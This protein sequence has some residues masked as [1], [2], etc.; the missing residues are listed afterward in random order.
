MKIYHL[1]H[2]S[3]LKKYVS[4]AYKKRFL[5]CTPRKQETL[6]N[7]LTKV[8]K[9]SSDICITVLQDIWKYKKLGKECFSKNL[10]DVTPI[11]KKKDPTLVENYQPVSILP[12]VS[13]VFEIT[14]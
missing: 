13:E 10:A 3:V 14:I 5:I 1:N 12:C 7:V 6:G 4:L 8:L 9:D 2:A 11:Y